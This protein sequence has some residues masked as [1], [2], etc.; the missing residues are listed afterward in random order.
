VNQQIISII[1][2]VYNNQE[3]I[4]DAIDSVLGQTYE[5]VEYIIV[6]GESNDN[7]VSIVK[8]YEDKIS[9]FVSKR[10]KGIY[11][12]LNKGV[13]FA[14]GDVVYVT[15]SIS[16]DVVKVFESDET[17]DAIKLEN[18]L[19]WKAYENFNSESID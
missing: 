3:T 11:Y 1:T 6:D 13:K 18:T 7:T 10:D 12:G 8:S 15:D 16:E 4:K 9:N 14:T 17:I 5:N 19:Y 2:S